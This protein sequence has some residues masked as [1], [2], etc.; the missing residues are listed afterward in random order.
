VSSCM[1]K[2]QPPPGG[3]SMRRTFE[4]AEEEAAE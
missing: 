4:A 3:Q 1:D 2:V